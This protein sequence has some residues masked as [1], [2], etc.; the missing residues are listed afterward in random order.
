[1]KIVWTGGLPVYSPI[2]NFFQ[3]APSTTISVLHLESKLWYE[4]A[5]MC[6]YSKYEGTS[7]LFLLQWILQKFSTLLFDDFCRRPIWS[8]SRI[9]I[10]SSFSFSSLLVS[11]PPTIIFNTSLYLD[12]FGWIKQGYL[13]RVKLNI[14]LSLIS[15]M[16]KIFFLNAQTESENTKTYSAR[17]DGNSRT[18]FRL[19]FRS[20]SIFCIKDFQNKHVAH[21]QGKFFGINAYFTNASNSPIPLR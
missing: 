12:V 8:D 15:T 20:L 1:M 6:H 5:C 10:S 2:F 4:L 21:K 18:D 14:M 11:E 19:C 17:L 9:S 7:V 13:Y 3:I 16:H